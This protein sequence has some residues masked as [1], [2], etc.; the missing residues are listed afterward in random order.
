[1][2]LREQDGDIEAGESICW[3]VSGQR[4]NTVLISA[5]SPTAPTSNTC[6]VLVKLGEFFCHSCHD[7]CCMSVHL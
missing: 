3:D 6:Y 2:A 7:G 5:V 4:W 1:V